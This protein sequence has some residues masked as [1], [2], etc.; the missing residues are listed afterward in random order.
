MKLC[1]YCGKELKIKVW[2]NQNGD[3]V[4]ACRYCGTVHIHKY[5]KE[6][7]YNEETERFYRR[8]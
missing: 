2:V 6:K 7:I 3:L 5:D 4:T 8:V 1:K